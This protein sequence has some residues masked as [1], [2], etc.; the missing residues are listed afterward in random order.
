M[1]RPFLFVKKKDGTMRMCIN[2]RQ[3][4]KVT[5]KNKYHLSSIDDLFD[6]LQGAYFFYLDS[7]VI[8]FID[9]ILVYS[10]TED[11]HDKHLRIALHRLREEK[12]YAK[13]S[14]FFVA[15]LDMWYP[16]RVLKWIKTRLR[17]LE[18]VDFTIYYDA[19]RVGLGGV[20]TQNGKVI[21]CAS[22][23]LKT[24]EKNYPTNDLEFIDVLVLKFKLKF[25]VCYPQ[26]CVALYTEK[27][28]HAQNTE[29]CKLAPGDLVLLYKARLCCFPA[30]SK[31]QWT[32][33]FRVTQVSLQGVVELEK[34][35]G[36]RFKAD[37]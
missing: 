32:G 27:K 16:R 31:S 20:L 12:L 24:H 15:S 34:R 9:D 13:F 11:D 6:K 35:N 8:V 1:R 36:T 2:Y 30:R 29:K 18:G 21:A 25:R 17:Q 33:P 19:S 26:L 28:R 4:N 37:Q 7:F 14:K 10:R 3:L 22:R 5:V 23:N